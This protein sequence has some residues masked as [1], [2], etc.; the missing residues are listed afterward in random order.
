MEYITRGLLHAAGVFLYV[1]AL[2]WFIFATEN[3]FEDPPTFLM[4]VFVL[5]L[6]IISALVTSSLVLGK[7]IH[8]YLSGKKRE[9]FVLLFA[10]VGW[11][12]VFL[13]LVASVLLLR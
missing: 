8:L 2:A 7:P 10:T 4:P 5:L 1:S 9:A 3:N 11:L 12:V 6:F 13:L